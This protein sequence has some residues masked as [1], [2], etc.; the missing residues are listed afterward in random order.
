MFHLPAAI[1]AVT[2]LL[3]A[4]EP[5]TTASAASE[6][7]G[8]AIGE[9]RDADGKPWLGAE[10]VLLSR[11]LPHDANAGEVDRVVAKVGERGRFRASILRGRPYTAWAWGDAGESGRPASAVVDRVFVQ[12]P[13]VL[14]QERVLPP[15]ELVLEH[16]ERWDGF[17]FRVRIVDNTWNREV[18]WLDVTDG[19][20]RLPWLVGITASIELLAIRNGIVHPLVS[21]DVAS[22]ASTRE[23]AI[24]VPERERATCRGL[25]IEGKPLA[26]ATVLRRLGGAFYEAGTLGADGTLALDVAVE[27]AARPLVTTFVTAEDRLGFCLRFERSDAKA[28][29]GKATPELLCRTMTTTMLFVRVVGLGER[30]LAGVEIWH[31]QAARCRPGTNDEVSDTYSRS[32]RTDESGLAALPHIPDGTRHM[33]VLLRERDLAALP[34]R[35]RPGLHPLVFAPLAAATG[36]GTKDAPFVID[37]SRL[38]PIEFAI[39]DAS[40]DPCPD[41]DV[42]PGMLVGLGGTWWPDRHDR[43]VADARGHV[44]LLLPPGQPLGLCAMNGMSVSL[45]VFEPVAIGAAD[46]PP[47]LTMQLRAPTGMRGRLLAADGEPTRGEVV[48]LAFSDPKWE[49]DLHAAPGAVTAG[50]ATRWLEP[51]EEQLTHLL[52]LISHAVVTGDDGAFAIPLPANVKMP[53]LRLLHWSG[54][55]GGTKI[56]PWLGEPVDDIV[57]TTP[58]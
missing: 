44:R 4:Q 2:T 11:P 28:N 7:R 30:P 10:V 57:L 6:L 48:P 29:G 46:E 50:N 42:A 23:V 19:R 26:G 8:P 54:D 14:K 39:T 15:R 36:A 22:T 51:N 37:L 1:A 38:C 17:T 3:L 20:A 5:D 25:S 35:W 45:R 27:Q 52:S 55:K 56:V 33:H 13:I 47:L 9:V 21:V 31:S 18:H 41:A 40:G 16:A 43:A 32:V 12:Q 34:P 24:D 58:R 53:K 49:S